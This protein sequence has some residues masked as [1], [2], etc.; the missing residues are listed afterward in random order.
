M[1]TDA[2]CCRECGE[3]KPA[4]AFGN[5]SAKKDGLR[6]YCKP[7]D[8]A[9]AKARYA[10]NR[11]RRLAQEK[12][13]YE[14]NREQ[15]RAAQKDY[16]DANRERIRERHK[17]RYDRKR[18]ELTAQKRAYRKTN[19]DKEREATRRWREANAEY[20]SEYLKKYREENRDLI[21]A[22]CAKRRA[23]ARQRA[24]LVT[25][26]L[27][28]RIRAIYKEA[29][30]LTERTG[31]AHHVDHIVPLYGETCS[32]LHHPDNLRVVPAQL[33][34]SKGNKIDY[35]LVPHAF[36]PDGT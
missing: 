22:L 3:V 33:N 28:K 4:E 1:T 35:E 18:E 24:C 26:E 31:I 6:S 13:R 29:R 8:V 2:K 10:K 27:E 25:P 5:D 30:R 9:K 17:E 16:A 7:C 23:G 15:I 11:E 34:L 36:R 14:A 21:Y 20:R 19:P 12:A 32:G